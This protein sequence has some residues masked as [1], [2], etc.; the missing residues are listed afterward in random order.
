LT[1]PHYY[2]TNNQLSLPEVLSPKTRRIFVIHCAAC[3]RTMSIDPLQ[4]EADAFKLAA[5]HRR[6]AGPRHVATVDSEL[7]EVERRM[8]CKEA[9]Q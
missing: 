8:I 2:K 3:E 5:D 7:R 4:D 9:R 6:L 1:S